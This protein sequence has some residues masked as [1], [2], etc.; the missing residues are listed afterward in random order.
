MKNDIQCEFF[1]LISTMRK[2]KFETLFGWIARS[3]EAS[4][5]RRMHKDSIYQTIQDISAQL[6][7]VRR[8]G[9]ERLG[10]GGR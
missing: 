9:D 7:E 4:K 3:I 8:A 5:T 6:A 2:N 10:K 1:M